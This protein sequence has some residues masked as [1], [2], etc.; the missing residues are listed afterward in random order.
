MGGC[1]TDLLTFIFNNA[2][3]YS[4]DTIE[5]L[6]RLPDNKPKV[7]G[8]FED[9]YPKHG[10][11]VSN[12]NYA[13]GSMTFTSNFIK[14]YK[15]FGI[16]VEN[17]KAGCKVGVQK[18]IYNEVPALNF[19]KGL[20]ME[21]FIYTQENVSHCYW[22]N[23]YLKNADLI[24]AMYCK[25]VL[26][27]ILNPQNENFVTPVIVNYNNSKSCIVP[28][29]LGNEFT[30]ALKN[31]VILNN[32]DEGAYDKTLHFV[33]WLS[34]LLHNKLTYSEFKS[35]EKELIQPI[36]ATSPYHNSPIFLKVCKTLLKIKY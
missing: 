21:K 32:I 16:F 18:I 4:P 33:E 20:N 9:L 28:E 12:T 22:K 24:T 25:T 8:E 13:T 30:N 34:N 35:L 1:D 3:L 14:P 27:Q 23:R 15:A 11:L 26:L 19:I 29:I 31:V 2:E 36:A 6:Y 7:M 5:F 10:I 17:Y